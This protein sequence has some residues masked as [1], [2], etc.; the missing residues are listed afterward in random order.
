LPNPDGLTRSYVNDCLIAA[1]AR[2]HGFVLVTLNGREFER[3]GEEEAFEFTSPRPAP[4]GDRGDAVRATCFHP[5]IRHPPRGRS[6][7]RV[8]SA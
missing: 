4:D 1:P 3:I 7:P 8:G 2:E 6:A 5:T